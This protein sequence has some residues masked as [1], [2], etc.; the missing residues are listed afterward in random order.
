MA[1]GLMAERE[2]STGTP[3]TGENF[4]ALLEESLGSSARFE[5]TVVKGRVVAIETDM[6]LVDVGLK[7]EGR[8]PLKEFSA[9]GKPAEVKLGDTVEVFVERVEDKNGEAQLSREK[10]RREEMFR[11]SA[12]DEKSKAQLL[13]KKFEEALKRSKD[14]PVVRPTRDF[15]LD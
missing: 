8:I 14:E 4:A 3:S 9:A 5:G 10:A 1:Q 12:E 13:E 11:K 2:T 7:S 6:V 15:D